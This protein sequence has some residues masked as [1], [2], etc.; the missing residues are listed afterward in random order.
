MEKHFKSSSA[1][2]SPLKEMWFAG[3]FSNRDFPDYSRVGRKKA[4]YFG[5]PNTWFHADFL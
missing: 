2:S 5:I 4:A 1:A 3:F